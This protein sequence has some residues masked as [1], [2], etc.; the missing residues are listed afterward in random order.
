S[1][2]SVASRERLPISDH[3]RSSRRKRVAMKLIVAIIRPE[4]LEAVQASLQEPE[5]CL[6]SVSQVVGNGRDP[7]F[8][9]LYR[10]R[11]V[12]VPRPKLRLEIAVHDA[13]VQGAVEAIARAGF[14]DD[15]GHLGRGNIFVMH[16]DEDVRIPGGEPRPVAIG[17]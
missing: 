15:S 7:G 16:L 8:T 1:W 6:V 2:W 12:R 10:G 9:E 4:K 17:R 11:E 13:Q 14:T 3:R 5:E